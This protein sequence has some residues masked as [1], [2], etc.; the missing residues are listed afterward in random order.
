MAWPY[1]KNVYGISSTI[2]AK[3]NNYIHFLLEICKQHKVSFLMPLTDL[4][5]D[6]INKYRD[7]F[8]SSNIQICISSKETLAI[9]RDKF[10]LYKCFKDDPNVP[11]ITTWKSGTSIIPVSNLPLIAKPYNGRSSEGLQRISD[12]ETLRL[13][14]NKPG[15][16]IQQIKEGNVFT[17]DY[18]RNNKTGK[19]AGVAREELLRTKNGAGITVRTTYDSSLLNLVSYIGKTIHIHGCVNM[20]FILSDNQYYLIDINPRFSAGV[21][22]SH[23]AG[24]NMVLNHLRCFTNEEIDTAVLYKEQILTKRYYEEIIKLTPNK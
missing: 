22:Y 7:C 20:E 14:E 23:L 19:D 4:E 18:V 17:V 8:E 10:A 3:S 16:I 24:Y 11:S 2:L 15:Y 1:L 21:A 12:E 5:I 6:V 13:I 9:A